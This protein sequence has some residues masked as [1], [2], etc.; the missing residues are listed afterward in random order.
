[1]MEVYMGTI[2]SFAFNYPPRGWAY[3]NGQIIA[4]STNSALFSL[5]GTTFG[6]NGVTTFALPDL[7]GRS[8]I[9]FGQG[10]GLSPVEM[11]QIAGTENITLITT[12]IPAH[13]HTL[14]SGTASVNVNVTA[15]SIVGGT[16][17][18]ETDNGNN[19]FAS[20]TATANIYSE[21][22]G[23]GT[24]TIKGITAV[25]GAT[26]GGNTGITGSGLPFPSRN[27]Y[28]GVN[29]CI[30]LNGLFPSRN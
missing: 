7:R 24:A 21:P 1:M 26:L 17:T 18:N 6:G 5:L 30:A 20:G 10:L 14:A 19:S 29:M 4:I 22:G 27:P 13:V 3:C 2:L 11:G 8:Q 16:I 9:H 25:A 12:N 23:T 15:T 28:L